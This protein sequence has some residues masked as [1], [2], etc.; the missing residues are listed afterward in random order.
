MTP[1]PPW[2]PYPSPARS[3][4]PQ[5]VLGGTHLS[6]VSAPEPPLRPPPPLQSRPL[7]EPTFTPSDHLAPRTRQSSASSHPLALRTPGCT[8]GPLRSNQVVCLR[9]NDRPRPCRDPWPRY[10]PFGRAPS[11]P[12]STLAPCTPSSSRPSPLDPS[13]SYR[14]CRRARAPEQPS[15]TA[16]PP[17]LYP[18]TVPFVEP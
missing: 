11:L 1:P 7:P 2:L 15:S 13:P 3:R 9:A 17:G 14:P 12:S 10:G 4:R 18:V 8:A 5:F 6:P 16:S